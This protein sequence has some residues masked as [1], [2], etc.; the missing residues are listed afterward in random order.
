ME[1]TEARLAPHVVIGEAGTAVP[2]VEF[3]VDVAAA[4]VVVFAIKI[5]KI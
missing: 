3:V 2:A 4:V 1:A 5:R